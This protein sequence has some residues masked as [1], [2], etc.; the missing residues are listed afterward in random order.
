MKARFRTDP[1][2]FQCAA[3]SAQGIFGNLFNTQLADLI[4]VGIALVLKGRPFLRVNGTGIADQMGRDFS[5]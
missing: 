5:R 4:A 3:L 1:Y 2:G